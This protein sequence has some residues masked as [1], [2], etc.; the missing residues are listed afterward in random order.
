MPFWWRKKEE[1]K[2]E[3]QPPQPA[4]ATPR[5]RIDKS[6]T[7]ENVNKTKS[8]LRLSSVER[9]I[10]GDALTRLYE[11]AAEGRITEE[12]RDRLAAKYKENITRL[13]STID[14][15]QKIIGLH[16]LEESRAELVKMFQDKFSELNVKIEEIR[17][18]LG[19]IPSVPKEVADV[20]FPLLPISE[21]DEKSRAGEKA[22]AT[23]PSAPRRTKADETLEK[24][25]EDLQK[26]LEKL[27][28]IEM[29]V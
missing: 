19:V 23:T 11:A 24:L 12:E 15:S 1:A 5:L 28:Q 25:R 2:D 20:K 4:L 29:E 8:E 14:H 27:E 22:V 13:D 21:R 16:E 6:F 26:Q 7:L 3:P 10:I 17:R 9:E 18:G